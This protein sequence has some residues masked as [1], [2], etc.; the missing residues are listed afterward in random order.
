MTRRDLLP[1]LL[2]ALGLFVIGGGALATEERD[3]AP[4]P[5]P[6]VIEEEATPID[7]VLPLPD[8]R[9]WIPAP[10][11]LAAF[12]DPQDLQEP[13]LP[14][15]LAPPGQPRQELE[16][17][18]RKLPPGATPGMLQQAI[19]TGTELPTLDSN[20]LGLTVLE[21]WITLGLPAPTVDSPLLITPGFSGTLVDAPAG[22]DLPSELYEGYV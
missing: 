18:G 20:G 6:P 11:R 19:F 2:A 13:L 21:K 7:P 17:K 3:D 14:D 5:L 15:D 1:P 9:E 22:V 4:Q 8:I 10:L 12:G 16:P